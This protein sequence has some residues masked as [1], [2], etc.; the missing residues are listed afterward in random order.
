MGAR[1]A[2][3]TRGTTLS[4]PRPESQLSLGHEEHGHHHWSGASFAAQPLDP[5]P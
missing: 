2:D 4:Q 3:E 1:E 5:F